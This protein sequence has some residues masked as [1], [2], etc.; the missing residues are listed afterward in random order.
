MR[1]AAQNNYHS[2]SVGSFLDGVDLPKGTLTEVWF[3]EVRLGFGPTFLSSLSSKIVKVD[4]VVDSAGRRA[5]GRYLLR[6]GRLLFNGLKD[7]LL[8][9]LVEVDVDASVVIFRDLARLLISY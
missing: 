7:L 8:L 3:F 1:V 4:F 9:L 6:V 5:R 2:E